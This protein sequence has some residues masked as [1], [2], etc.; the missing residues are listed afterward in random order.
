MQDG[1]R[2]YLVHWKATW[3]PESSLI[4]CE[5]LLQQF[6]QESQKKTL[7]QAQQR[8]QQLLQQPTTETTLYND[9]NLST[10]TTK[11]AANQI[12]NCLEREI[13]DSETILKAEKIEGAQQYLNLTKKEANTT[14]NRLS[15]GQQTKVS[16]IIV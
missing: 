10:D 1:N 12:L 4:Y 13:V 9:L 15:R 3:K 7:A 11:E 8:Q 2:Y 14:S 5:K 16:F 6:W